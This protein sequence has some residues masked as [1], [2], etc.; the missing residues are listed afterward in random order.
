MAS[1]S[2]SPLARIGADQGPDLAGHD[3]QREAAR[4]GASR[5]R[6]ETGLRP[7]RGHE[8]IGLASGR[9]PAE[10]WQ[11]ALSGLLPRE[12]ATCY[13]QRLKGAT[14]TRVDDI[15]Q[16]IAVLKD[17]LTTLDRERSK[18]A[19]RLSA[20]EHV[21]ARGLANQQPLLG[22]RVTTASST[23]EKI[24]VFRSL[25]RGRE[26]VFPRRWENPKSGKSGYAPVCRNEWIRGVCGKPQ[27]KCG[28]CPNQ[29][30]VPFED[31]IIRSH[32]TGRVTGNA[33]DFTAGIY[34]MLPDETCW[35]L[36]ADFDK[37]SWKR[38]VVAFAIRRGQ[39]A[40]PLRSNGPA[41]ATV[42]M[43]G[44]SSRNL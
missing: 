23:A 3:V 31:D 26:N 38:D 44:S 40:F 19:D 8:A 7:Q 9:D 1:A 10:C 5:R 36:A 18:L 33:T 12:Y 17:R 37:K 35:F 30:F 14:I 28:E 4:A 29:A 6:R 13:F 41:R 34:P 2:Q 24:A 43:R 42:L 39:R 25:F 32:L 21:R 16:E 11:D 20:L 22:A 27:V 15:D